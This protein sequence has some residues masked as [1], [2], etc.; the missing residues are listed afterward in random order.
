MIRLRHGD[1]ERFWKLYYTRWSE[2]SL[3]IMT[4]FDAAVEDVVMVVR[5][6]DRRL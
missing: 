5:D 4:D 2:G 3:E 6:K 1:N